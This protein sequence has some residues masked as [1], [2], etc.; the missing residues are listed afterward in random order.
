MVSEDVLLTLLDL[1]KA[2]I[3]I[4]WSDSTTDSKLKEFLESS[5][6]WFVEKTGYVEFNYLQAST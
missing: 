5:I 4:T 6:A 1:L 3:D 2:K